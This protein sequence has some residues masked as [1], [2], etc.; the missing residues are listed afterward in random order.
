[1]IASSA[2]RYWTFA[3]RTAYVLEAT[4]AAASLT[5]ARALAGAAFVQV[6]VAGGTT[7]SGTVSLTG[8]AP[9][10]GALSEVL[11]FAANGTQVTAK[12]F[13]T[14]TAIATTG[15]ANEAAVPTVAVQ[16]VSADGTPQFMQV[17]VAADRPVVVG[18]TG[19]FDYP[20]ATQ[21]TQELDGSIT[22]VDYEEVWCP[23]V[24]DLC[25]EAATGEVWVVR[26]VREVRVGFGVRPHHW[27]LRCSRY[28]T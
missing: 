15:L 6:T 14:V 9:G 20:A 26:G 7:G 17:E 10:G 27:Q 5:P 28:T 12:R 11:T 3:R 2:S 23:R 4:A 16:A 13:A 25:T 24:D 21:G 18:W 19:P 22:L 1:M 8:T